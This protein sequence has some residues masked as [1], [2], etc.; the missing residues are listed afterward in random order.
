MGL[1]DTALLCLSLA[2]NESL[3]AMLYRGP[4]LTK[5]PQG[6]FRYSFLHSSL[7]SKLES[8]EISGFRLLGQELKQ[9]VSTSAPGSEFAPGV[10]VR[11]T[12]GSLTSHAHGHARGFMVI[13]A[14]DVPPASPFPFAGLRNAIYSIRL[15]IDWARA[16]MVQAWW[17]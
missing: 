3:L 16:Q 1:R 6:L 17:I 9:S 15:S 7:R 8:L 2:V 13:D 10:P 12:E 11:T 14:N 5:A 4:L